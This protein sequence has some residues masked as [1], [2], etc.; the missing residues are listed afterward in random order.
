MELHVFEGLRMVE[1]VEVGTTLLK[2]ELVGLRML[3][4]GA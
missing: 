3:G 4:K 2:Y 1:V